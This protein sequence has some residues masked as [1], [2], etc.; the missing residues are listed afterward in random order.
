MPSQRKT[1]RQI[2]SGQRLLFPL[3]FLIFAL[4]PPVHAA[5]ALPRALADWRAWVLDREDYRACPFAGNRAASDANDFFC[6]WPGRLELALSATGGSFSQRWLVFA[7]SWMAFP[8][9]IERW[10]RDVTLNVDIAPG[11]PGCPNK[12]GFARADGRRSL[13]RAS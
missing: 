4:A 2:I 3:V 13:D 1:Q 6:A 8:G 9:N 11:V 7:D 10:P 12:H 5:P